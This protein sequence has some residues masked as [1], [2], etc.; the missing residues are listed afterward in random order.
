MATHATHPQAL[1]GALRTDYDEN[2]FLGRVNLEAL[3]TAGISG[4]APVRLF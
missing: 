2:D 3:T 1:G 4:W